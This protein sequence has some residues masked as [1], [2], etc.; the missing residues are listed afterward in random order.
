VNYIHFFW[1]R[2]R[3]RHEPQ[4]LLEHLLRALLRHKVPAL[5]RT[6]RHLRALRAALLPGPDRAAHLRDDAVGAPQRAERA[7]ADL[8]ARGEVRAVVFQIDRG[9]GAVVLARLSCV[10]A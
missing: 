4:N 10:S 8:L 5:E 7:H 9:R 2:T 3:S 1:T 6:A